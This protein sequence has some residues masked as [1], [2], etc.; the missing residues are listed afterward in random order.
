MTYKRGDF[1]H[2]PYDEIGVILKVVTDAR[3]GVGNSYFIR[4]ATGATTWFMLAHLCP[5]SGRTVRDIK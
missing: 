2:T 4:L 3:E 1:V 5:V